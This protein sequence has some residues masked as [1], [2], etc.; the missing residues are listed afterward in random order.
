MND[1]LTWVMIVGTWIAALVI[2]VLVKR[3][4]EPDASTEPDLEDGED[5]S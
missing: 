5:Y 4:R 1:P 3:A 2:A